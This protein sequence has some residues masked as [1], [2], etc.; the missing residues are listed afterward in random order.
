[1]SQSDQI[2][3]ARAA[4]KPRLVALHQIM[5]QLTSTLSFMNTGAHP[6]DETTAMLAI[7]VR[8]FGYDVSVACSTRG[9]GGQNVIGQEAGAAL[10]VLRTAEMERAAAALDLRMYWL[11]QS[12]EDPITDF[13]FSKSGEETL[14]KWGKSHT[15]KRFVDILRR[16]RPDIICPTFLDVPGQHGHHRAMTQAAFEAFDL[17]ADPAYT[18]CDLPVWEV[19]KLY[20]PAWSGAGLAYDDD[21][22]PPPATTILEAQGHDPV[23]GLSF[24]TLGQISRAYHA[25]QGMGQWVPL[26]MSRDFP[27]HLAT[28]RVDGEEASISSGLL[29]SLADFGDPILERVHDAIIEAIGAISDPV[30]MMRHLTEALLLLRGAKKVPELAHK[31]VRKEAQISEAL[32][33]ASGLSVA[34]CLERIQLAP[35]DSV[36]WT[37]EKWSGQAEEARVTL[38]HPEQW[39]ATSTQQGGDITTQ[40]A[41][42]TDSYPDTW[43]PGDPAKPR[44]KVEL[45]FG[46]VTSTTYQAFEESPLVF[47]QRS[48]GLAPLADVINL[49]TSRRQIEL[50]LNNIAPSGAFPMFDLP[51]DWHQQVTATGLNVIV[52]DTAKPGLYELP[53][54]LDEHPAETVQLIQHSH[55]DQRLLSRPAVFKLRV[56]EVSLPK[57]RIGYIGG[58]NDRV[59]HWLDQLGAD[60]TRLEEDILPERLDDFDTLVIGIFAIRTRSLKDAMPAIHAW[61][62]RGGT[63]VTLYHRPWDAWDAV[64]TAPQPLQIGQ[65]SLRWRVTDESAAV[66][67]LIEDHPVLNVPNPIEPADWD[68]WHKERG[69]YFAKSW[70]AAYQPL[71]EMADPDED[72]HQGSLL[73]ADIG[74]GRHIHCALILHH[75]MEHLV[76]GAFR[77]MANFCLAR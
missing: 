25:T 45:G 44:L 68:G 66:T 43:L 52:P 41:S 15:V 28:S 4:A 64:E 54:L 53:L 38:D 46:G 30:T 9:E 24:E 59:D 13:G 19:K 62:K 60:V 32:R 17:A 7:M 6:D 48:A 57:A 56:M 34:G 72:P 12:P 63:L 71:L 50:T 40:G 69:L 1:M 47:P 31:L 26:G 18:E 23:T 35:H 65:P 58:G 29:S 36:G 70:D 2:R 76:A 51:G 14:A 33:L 37:L 20:L 8:H 27:L 39:T 5:T 74:Q 10:G 22:P 77:L 3:L 49:K 21:V 67:T 42:V 16:E 75:Q 11:S 73:V 61:V 55:V